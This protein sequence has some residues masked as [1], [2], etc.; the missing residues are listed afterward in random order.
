MPKNQTIY[1]RETGVAHTITAVSA[2]E[3]C[4][5]HPKLWSRVPVE[6]KRPEAAAAAAAAPEPET[7]SDDLRAIRGIGPATLKKLNDAGI[8]TYAALIEADHTEEPFAGIG[9]DD[10]WA[11]WREQ[12]QELSA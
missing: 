8:T 4:K 6:V 1:N 12:A 9:D 7:E 5:K 3:A 2:E 11:S 10:D